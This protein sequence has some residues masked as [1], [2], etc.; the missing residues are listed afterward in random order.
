MLGILLAAALVTQ[1]TIDVREFGA[2]GD[3][4]ADDTAAIQRAA[5]AMNGCRG[6]VVSEPLFLV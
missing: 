2:K 1:G 5:D 6:L 3:G 4:V